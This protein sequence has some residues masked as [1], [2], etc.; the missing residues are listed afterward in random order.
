MSLANSV[1]IRIL[2]LDHRMINADS[3]IVEKYLNLNE[4]KKTGLFDSKKV[5]LFIKKMQKVDTISEIDGM[6][7][8]GLFSTQILYDKFITSFNIESEN[9]HP[10]N[11][12][13]DLRQNE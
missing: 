7:L 5:N 2:F 13:F 6:T 1:E 11:V 12:I 8:I 9:I 4:L 3:R 10:F